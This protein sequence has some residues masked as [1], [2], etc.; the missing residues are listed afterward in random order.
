MCEHCD[1]KQFNAIADCTPFNA[2]PDDR[3]EGMQ[4]FYSTKENVW[5]LQAY[6]YC[7]PDRSRYQNMVSF[8]AVVTHCPWCGKELTADEIDPEVKSYFERWRK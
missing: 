1:K 2:S 3:V 7:H 5:K 6:S 4:L 8:V